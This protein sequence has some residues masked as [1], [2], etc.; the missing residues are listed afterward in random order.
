MEPIKVVF[1]TGAGISQESGIKTFRDIVDGLWLNYPV[2][3]VATLSGVFN[4]VEQAS[5]FLNTLKKEI[6]GAKPNDAHLAIAELSK[7]PRFDVIVITQNVDDLHK[8]SGVP[9]QNIFELHGNIFDLICR[10]HPKVEGTEFDAEKGC[11]RV[12][13]QVDHEWK[14]PQG[15]PQCGKKATVSPHVVL[16]EEGLDGSTLSQSFYHASTADIFIQVGTSS[17]VYPAASII[18]EVN[19]SKRIYVDIADQSEGDPNQYD[20][21]FVG[22]A[23]EEVVK[24]CDYIKSKYSE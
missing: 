4:N 17:Q 1:L 7:D 22:K 14:F 23:T 11:Y 12:T 20:K 13:K 24:V 18:E 21:K 10:S 8:K 16:F 9:E 6:S 15:C 5:D 3:E 19:I 2:M